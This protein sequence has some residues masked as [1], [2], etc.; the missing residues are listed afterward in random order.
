MASMSPPICSPFPTSSTWRRPGRHTG[1][2][3]PLTVVAV[4]AVVSG[5]LAQLYGQSCSTGVTSAYCLAP[6]GM[7][8]FLALGGSCGTAQVLSPVVDLHPD[9]MPELQSYCSSRERGHKGSKM[10]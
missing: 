1:T 2:P 10:L 4:V 5:P 6:G 3:A 7:N 9:F 8:I